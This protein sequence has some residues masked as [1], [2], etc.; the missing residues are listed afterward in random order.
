MHGSPSSIVRSRLPSLAVLLAAAFAAATEVLSSASIAR[1]SLFRV[2]L[3]AT[4]TLAALALALT[5]ALEKGWLTIALALDVAPAPPGSR[6][7][8]PSRSCVGSRPSSPASW[9]CGSAMNRASPAMR[10]APRRSSTGCCGV[11]AFRRWRSGRRL[12][13]A[14]APRRCPVADGGIRRHRF[15]RAAGLHGNSPCGQWRRC[16]CIQRRPR[17]G[18]SSGLR[19][20]R[21][22]DRAGTAAAAQRQHRAQHRRHRACRFRRPRHRLRPAHI[23]LADVHRRSMSA[24]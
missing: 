22:G 16:L 3:F 5:F 11:T 20:T 12:A 8:G 1:V 2:A 19:H 6:C 15:H 14:P 23:G 13:A 24:A 9:C 21:H 18:R 4:A 10:W 17:R 7:S